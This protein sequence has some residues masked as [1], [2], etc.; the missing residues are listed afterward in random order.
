MADLGI[1][2]KIDPKVDLSKIQNQTLELRVDAAVLQKS[3]EHALNYKPHALKVQIDKAYL[4]KQINSIMAATGNQSAIGSSKQK[5]SPSQKSQSGYVPFNDKQMANAKRKIN[6]MQQSINRMSQKVKPVAAVSDF[7]NQLKQLHQLKEGTIEWSRAYDDLITKFQR[8]SEQ[9]KNLVNQEKAIKTNADSAK[10]MANEKAQSIKF[11][12]EMKRMQDN[13]YSS[14]L[15]DPIEKNIRQIEQAALAEADRARVVNELKQQMAELRSGYSDY[16]GENTLTNREIREQEHL[17]NLYRQANDLLRNNPKIKGTSYQK[18]L[19]GIMNDALN[20]NVGHAELSADLATIRAQMDDLG[21]TTESTGARLKRLFHDHMNTAIAMAGLHALQ[22]SFDELLKSVINVDTAMTDLKK[23]SNGTSQ[24]YEAFLTGANARAKDLGA[25]VTDVIGASAEFSRLGYNLKDSATLGDAAV[26]Y[27]N[28]SEY[29]NIEDAAQSLVSTMQAFGLGADQV[30]SI[31]DKFNQ[32]GNN[33]AISSSGL[34]EAMQRSAAALSLAGNTL[35]ESLGLVTAANEVV[36]DPDVVGT[37]A[38]TLTMYLRAAKTDAEAAGIETVGMANSVSE[39]RDTIMSLTSKTS[40]PVDI[41]V[42]DSTFKSTTQ[43]M[44]EIA[45]VF[46]EMSDI[47]QASLLKTLSGKRLANTTAALLSNWETVEE[48]IESATNSAGSADIENEKYLNSIQGKLQQFK[49]QFEATSTSI[50]NSELVKGTIDTG[51]GLLGAVQWLTDQFGALPGF[52][53]PVLGMISSFKNVGFFQKEIM[54]DGSRNYTNIISKISQWRKSQ[55]EQLKK[56]ENFLRDYFSKGKTLSDNELKRQYKGVSNDV[57]EVAKGIDVAASS[58]DTLNQAVSNYVKQQSLAA[59]ATT[60]LANAVKGIGALFGN[61]LISAAAMW[62]ISELIKFFDS[63]TVSAQEAAETTAEV[64]QAYTQNTE[65]IAKSLKYVESMRDRFDE[66]SKGVSDSGKNISLTTAEFQEYN[67]IA[68]E[69]ANI[70]PA[71]VKGYTAEGQAIVDRN[72]AIEDSIELLKRQRVE[73][74]KT[75]IYGGTSTNDGNKTN[76]QVGYIDFSNKYKSAVKDSEKAAR[77][78]ATSVSKIYSSLFSE[79]TESAKK[80]ADVVSEVA[81]G[82]SFAEFADK[83]REQTGMEA[84]FATLVSSQYEKVAANMPQIISGA[85][86]LG[87][88]TKAQAEELSHVDKSYDNVSGQ[89]ERSADSFRTLM[90]AIFESEEGYF[91]LNE[92]E[93]N[94]LNS[95]KN[96]IPAEELIALGEDGVLSITTGMVEGL[97]KSI[98]ANGIA[99][100]M[101]NLFDERESIPAKEYVDRLRKMVQSMED[102]LKAEGIEVELGDIF[103]L[104]GFESDVADMKNSIR[105]NIEDTFSDVQIEGATLEDIIGSLDLDGLSVDALEGLN[106]VLTE[107]RENAARY[108][109]AIAAIGSEGG[110]SALNEVLSGINGVLAEQ[111]NEFRTVSQDI[112]EYQKA[113]EG[114]VDGADTHE[115]MVDIYEE[116]AKSVAKGQINTEEAREQMD[117]LIGKV[118]DLDEAKKWVAENEGFFITGTDEDKIGQDLTAGFSTLKEKYNQLGEEQRKL[119]DSMM[120]VDWD[121]GSITVAQNDVVKLADAFGVSATT[122][123]QFFDLVETYSDYEIPTIDK[124]GSQIES[125]NN[126]IYA[127]KQ[128]VPEAVRATTNAWDHLGPAAKT[129]LEAI[130]DGLDIDLTQLKVEELDSLIATYNKVKTKLG[131][132]PSMEGLQSFFNELKTSTGAAVAEVKKMSGGEWAIDFSSVQD[133]AAAL[134]TSEQ[135]ARILMGT[136]TSLR[137]EAGKPIAV[138]VNG[139]PA[140][141]ELNVQNDVLGEYIAKFAETYSLKVNGDQAYSEIT[142][143]N[144]A[145]TNFKSKVI[146][147]TAKYDTVGT[148]P[149]SS[150]GSSGG[151]SSGQNVKLSGAGY[152]GMVGKMSGNFARGGKSK[153]GRI[154]TGELGRELWIS[155]DGKHQKVVGKD[156]M[157]IIRTQPGDAIVPNDIT[158]QLISGGMSS[159]ADGLIPDLPVSR[160]KYGGASHSGALSNLNSATG[161]KYHSWKPSSKNNKSKANVNVNA[162]LN[163]KKLEDQMKE[164]LDKLKEEIE[165]IFTDLE[166]KIFLNQKNHGPLDETLAYYKKIQSEANR[167][168]NM[169]RKKG[170]DEN[171]EYIQAMQKQ[172]WDAKDAMADAVKEYYEG[173][174]SHSENRITLVENDLENAISNKE[175]LKTEDY[176]NQIIAQYRKLQQT[177]HEQAEQY[178]KLGY[179]DTSDEVSELSDKWWDFENEIKDVK[180]QVVDSLNDIVSETSNAIDDL[181]DVFDTLQKAADEY[182]QSGGYISVD[183]FQAIVELGPQYL[184]YLRDENGL[185]KINR[186]RLNEVMKA[187]AEQLALESAMSYV[188][189]LRM[190]M[191]DKDMIKLNQLLNV[192]NQATKSTWG[193]LYAQLAILGLS[194][195]GYKAA[196]HNVQALQALAQN[197]IKGP[198]LDFEEM[199]EGADKLLDYV[200]D[201]IRDQVEEQ[202]DALEEMKDKYAELIDLK[203]ESLEAT[204]AENDYQD[205]VAEKVTEIADLQAKINLLSL[206]DSRSAQAQRAELEKQL[207]ELQK[208]LSDEQADHAL[209]KQTESLDKMQEAYDKQKDDE[210]AKLEQS[211]SSTEK[212]YQQAIDYIRN[213]W[214]TLKDD[215]IKWNYEMGSSFEHEITDA[216]KAAQKA[217]EQYGSYLDYLLAKQNS[218]GS[219]GSGDSGSNDVVGE[220]TG[221]PSYTDSEYAQAIVTQMKQNSEA[222]HGANA[223]DRKYLEG[224][225]QRLSEM[226]KKAL[227]TDNIVLKNGD[228]YIDGQL[229]YPKYYHTGG[230]VGDQGSIKQNEMMAV[231]E[232][233][234]AVLDL[235]KQKSLM[236]ILN[237]ASKLSSKLDVSKNPLNTSRLFEGVRNDIPSVKNGANAPS[238]VFGDTIINGGD[239]ST[240]RKHQEISRK[241]VNEVLD[242]FNLRK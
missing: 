160:A 101:K 100:A 76:Y 33:F 238:I 135:N 199:Q 113:V 81:T 163:T 212:L 210:I 227:G 48:V 189:Q 12:S 67:E 138:T 168:A 119:V 32:V 186:E 87:V 200:M 86:K 114:L 62:A 221:K 14:N 57:M 60:M 85:T 214:N 170:L 195:D 136:I 84:E 66:L 91:R 24:D 97:N 162:S 49:A 115:S 19:E 148:P 176:A 103:N 56:D 226:L 78:S 37:W 132:K 228:W 193:F 21:L 74:A 107:G 143:L 123:Q 102:A 120:H 158:E 26:K 230:I 240:I 239:E 108:V 38:K 134:G 187:K 174:T 219:S 99:Q 232:R 42:N 215:L 4:T 242:L 191:R 54:P 9:H 205:S 17:N 2:I 220:I 129:A 141:S 211:I 185:L 137:D 111:G 43:I 63:L 65:S 125:L 64:T 159:A 116:F 35:D 234:E 79:N 183:S 34:G 45:G 88:L 164:A 224:E 217:A 194:E 40:K 190:A 146:T 104:S 204:K 203:K 167:Y 55:N 225:N 90:Q 124:F 8:A 3:I 140:E 118:V 10:R 188:E 147:L 95:F 47:D 231:L 18:S 27:L 25:T 110:A 52:I 150:G 13:G 58:Q 70:S 145:L 82:G 98:K 130:T 154:L 182:A 218:L 236:K 237:F 23:V 165:D 155:R 222:W 105:A 233:D 206:D 6:Q 177:I 201:M 109:A 202:I 144:G 157:E 128:K 180:Q 68:S 197:V 241:M 153:G 131:E 16:R 175:V 15:Y 127:M 139:A 121:T 7:D 126:D 179:S 196:I 171:S 198:G 207:A 75:A 53:S 117:L 72:S 169:Y 29:T 122:L 178:R 133:L 152:A 59:K 28:V 69:I 92:S 39:V 89:I 106:K 31:V 209:D 184:S 223:A 112:Q 149:P 156:G 30:G 161:G 20:G 173:I 1:E 96:A 80:F 46:D 94:F 61:M 181:Q 216:W 77:A 11:L 229:L 93:K 192:T 71:L 50:L 83:Y 213:N 22:Y 235:P 41:M 51:S 36:Q 73:E 151:V 44:R 172:W 166:H 5:H 142:K 208:D